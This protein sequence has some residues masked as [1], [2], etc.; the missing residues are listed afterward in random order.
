MPYQEWLNSDYKDKQSCQSCHMPVIQEPVAITKVLGVTR[1]DAS[2]HVFVG[3]NFFIQRML[4]RYRA[5]L[6]VIALP[7][8]FE[9]RR[10]PYDRASAVED[11]RGRHPE[12]EYRSGTACRPISRCR[13]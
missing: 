10:Q 3:G 11:G 6:N 7:E 4:N 13:I 8:E 12:C 1:E 5:D 9:V 2:R